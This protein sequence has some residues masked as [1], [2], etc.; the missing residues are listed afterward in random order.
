MKKMIVTIIGVCI[1]AGLSMPTLSKASDS[2]EVTIFPIKFIINGKEKTVDNNEYTVFNH[3]GH[4]YVPVRFIAENLGAY[5]GYDHAAKTITL[6]NDNRILGPKV[7][8]DQAKLVAFETYRLE[9]IYSVEL[10][11][12]SD[13][14]LS[15]IPKDP[16]DKTP[17]YFVILGKDKS[18]MEVT[19]YVS[20]NDVAHHYKD[21]TISK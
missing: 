7:N 13:T 12:L 2:I 14:E 11:M 19:V 10:R 15:K 6:D 18:S 3:N 20:S 1:I 5:I 17:V 8:R 21:E 9:E 4:A 16:K